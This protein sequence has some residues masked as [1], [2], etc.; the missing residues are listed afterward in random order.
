MC[1]DR[2]S[3]SYRTV[4]S[5]LPSIYDK[6][7]YETLLVPNVLLTRQVDW[8]V[9]L[10]RLKMMDFLITVADKEIL[11]KNQLQLNQ[12]LKTFRVNDVYKVFKELLP[13]DVFYTIDGYVDRI[14]EVTNKNTF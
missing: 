11:S 8:L 4:F 5:T 1:L 14:L 7:L 6:N 9:V 13:L 3:K 2:S 12:V 10:S